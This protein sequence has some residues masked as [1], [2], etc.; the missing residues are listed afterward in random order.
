MFIPLLHIGE[1]LLKGETPGYDAILAYLPQIG[2]VMFEVI[3]RV[4]CQ[5]SYTSAST[6]YNTHM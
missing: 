2:E 1:E 5:G 4:K 3:A 6:R